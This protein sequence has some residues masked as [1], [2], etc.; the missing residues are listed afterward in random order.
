MAPAIAGRQ[1]DREHQT[2]F[3]DCVRTRKEPAANAEQGHYSALLCH[4]ANISYRV[5]NKKLSF[6]AKTETFKDAPDANRLLKRTYR[7][8][9]ILTENT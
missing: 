8:P 3:L 9:W 1:A 5:G 4:L 7:A 6:D 2:N